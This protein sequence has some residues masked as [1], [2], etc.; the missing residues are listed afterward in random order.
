VHPSWLRSRADP[1]NRHDVRGGRLTDLRVDLDQVAVDAVAIA[2]AD[3]LDVAIRLVVAA[4]DEGHIGEP[5]DVP[6]HQRPGRVVLDSE[7]TDVILANDEPDID[8]THEL[9]DRLESQAQAGSGRWAWAVGVGGCP[10]SGG[11]ID[12]SFEGACAHELE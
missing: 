3:E 11:G 5:G 4:A 1:Q 8:R 12:H 9:G 10:A 7:E 2:T 6:V